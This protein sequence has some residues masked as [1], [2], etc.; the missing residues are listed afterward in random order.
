MY[1][2][3]NLVYGNMIPLIADKGK[4]YALSLKQEA[5]RYI[6]QKKVRKEKGVL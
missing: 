6:R 4:K 2:P 5:Q 3:V 1:P